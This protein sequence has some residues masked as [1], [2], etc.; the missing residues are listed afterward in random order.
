[1]ISLL[2]LLLVVN[3]SAM[4]H[5]LIHYH[6]ENICLCCEPGF[7]ITDAGNCAI[8]SIEN[9]AIYDSFLTCVSCTPTFKLSDGICVKDFSGCIEYLMP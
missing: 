2:L 9:C 1:M 5:C 8:H 3:T 7:M 6:D 4:D